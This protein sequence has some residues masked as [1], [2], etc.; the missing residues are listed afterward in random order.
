MTRRA[1]LTP[2]TLAVASAPVPSRNPPRSRP[3]RLAALLLVAGA[4]GAS[5][6]I[7]ARIGDVVLSVAQFEAEASQL[8]QTG[9]KEIAA[10]D[11]A[12]K[13]RVL[14]GIIARHLLLQEGQRRGLD[15]DSTVASEVAR[16]EQRALIS[17]LYETRAL[18]PDYAFTEAELREHFTAAHFDVEVLSRHIV[19]DTEAEA[20]QVLQAL[21]DSVPFGTLVELHSRTS[22]QNL[23]GP[24]GWVG[25]FKLG[26]VLEELEEPLATMAP[27]TLY[28][29]P[30][31][32]AVGYHVFSLQDRR[33]VNFEVEREWVRER[34]RV[35]RRADDMARYVQGLRERY[36]L[37]P[38]PEGF[39]A[40]AAIRADS[41][42]GPGADLLLFSWTGGRLTVGDYMAQQRAGRAQHPAS[43]DSAG[44]YTSADN[45]AGR[46]I[47]AAEGRRLGLDADPAVRDKV[48]RRQNELLVEALFRTEAHSRVPP[49]FSDADARAFY[50]RN[51]GLFTRAD[52]RVTDFG[53]LRNSILTL[54]RTQAETA[55]MDAF[56]GQLRSTYRDRIEVHPEALARAFAGEA[57]P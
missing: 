22:I 36:R 24:G 39:P 21:A 51:L 25:W 54:M 20:R 30:V 7:V 28:P 53:F 17:R 42:A 18:R 32:T 45:L 55:A 50:E 2:S 43:L 48:V 41:A 10:W 31:K 5:D 49:G 40:L 26:D 3:A 14:D 1:G 19:C 16:A 37:R 27:G 56:L 15:R 52:G 29:E 34:L 12:A 9:Y 11:E 57:P 38:H 35:Q 6:P 13:R 46:Q 44:R 23:F 33:P 47:M 8:R 4:V